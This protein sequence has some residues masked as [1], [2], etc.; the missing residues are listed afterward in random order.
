MSLTYVTAFLKI[1]KTD[2]VIGRSLS[3]RLDAAEHLL[4]SNIPLVIF[5]SSC[6][7]DTVKALSKGRTGVIFHTIELEELETYALLK[8]FQEK[9]P[10][11]RNHEK[12][13][14]EYI[15]LMN[16]KA[17][18]VNRVIE[19]NPFGTTQFAWA[20]FCLFHIFQNPF[21]N[22]QRLELLSNAVLK[23][24]YPLII[25]GCWH[26]KQSV[27]QQ[28]VHWRFCGGFFMG[29][30]EACIQFY[31]LHKK[32]LPIAFDGCA[33]EVNY[34]AYMEQ[35]VPLMSWYRGDHNDCM[36]DVP[37]EMFTV[38]PEKPF[39]QL[40][41]FAIRSGAYTYPLI[42]G[43]IPTSSSYLEISGQQLLNVRH[44]NYS[45][46]P[47]GAYIINDPQGFLKTENLILQLKNYE[48]VERAVAI[49]NRVDYPTMSLNIQ[50]LED[51]RLYEFEQQV[52]FIATQRQWSPSHQNR[53]AIG[54][55]AMDRGTFEK[56]QVIDPPAPTSCEK[57]WIP[58]IREGTE[59]F[60]YQ[61]Y[62][63]QIGV[64]KGGKLEIVRSFEMPRA[65][66]KVRGSTLF[67]EVEEGLLGLV[68]YSEE[69]SP[70]NYYHMLMLLSK[71]TLCPVAMSQPFV[72]GR[73]G[74]EFCIGMA[75][76][77]TDLQFWYSQHDRDPA[78][79]VVP[80]TELLLR[81]IFKS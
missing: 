8:P 12:D 65:F 24:E 36:I 32:Y 67:T 69:R 49:T 74:I 7:L 68:H 15:T 55:V 80:R 20:D 27:S 26:H 77:G 76:R 23:P 5:V 54:T 38:K 18:F 53:M 43:Y 22:Q 79:L 72:F 45:L 42:E 70:R 66:Q 44:V 48:E 29:T 17:E 1:Y 14:F 50:G 21:L 47:Q 61:W 6:Y 25:P 3:Y 35:K 71:E 39:K 75:V 28:N 58:L 60:I 4:T 2:V 13:T 9:L 81:P 16:A 46:T 57:N 10:A 56:V 59:Q 62:P 37:D 11:H 73:I 41:H 63:Y 33:W 52:K 40:S 64:V 30:K 31:D 34:W 78:W 19:M 51:I